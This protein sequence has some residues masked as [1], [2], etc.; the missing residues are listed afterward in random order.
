MELTNKQ[1]L[2][3]LRSVKEE[4]RVRPAYICIII[5]VKCIP[6]IDMYKYAR[7]NYSEIALAL[8][9]ELRK[10]KPEDKRFGYEWF[11]DP[12]NPKSRKKRLEVVQSLIEEIGK[13]EKQ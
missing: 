1:R 13:I 8:F 7:Y 12:D 6:L 4:M 10:Y 9:P 11:G 5:G 2:E 3:I